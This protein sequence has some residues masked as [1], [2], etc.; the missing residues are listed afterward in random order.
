MTDVKGFQLTLER[1]PMGPVSAMLRQ[2]PT[3]LSLNLG[4]DNTAKCKILFMKLILNDSAAAHIP[5]SKGLKVIKK[6][7]KLQ[8]YSSVQVI[9]PLLHSKFHED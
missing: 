6:T 8:Y 7:E 2:C 9:I 5:V 4:I 3:F 1:H